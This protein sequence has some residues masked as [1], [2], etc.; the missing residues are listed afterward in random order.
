MLRHIPEEDAMWVVEVNVKGHRFTHHVLG[1]ERLRIAAR[2][3]AH[4][5]TR[6]RQHRTTA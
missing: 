4:Q 1:T 5:L 6:L 3:A 2:G